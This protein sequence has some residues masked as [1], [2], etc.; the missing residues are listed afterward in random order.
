MAKEI[1]STHGEGVEAR[2]H[3]RALHYCFVFASLFATQ[4]SHDVKF[5]VISSSSAKHMCVVLSTM[6]LTLLKGLVVHL[7]L[8]EILMR[9]HHTR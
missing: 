1:I 7:G 5:S 9:G 3:S 6:N 4:V 2:F 8:W